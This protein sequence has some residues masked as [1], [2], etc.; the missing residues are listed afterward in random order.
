MTWNNLL[1]I[2]DLIGPKGD[3]GDTGAT[4]ATGSAGSDGKTILYG[5]VVPTSE[6]NDGDFYIRT[7]TNYLYGP[8][9]SGVWPSGTSLVGATGATGATG[10][11]GTAG[12]NGVDGKTILYGTSAPVSEGNN[13]DFYIRTS[14]N[15]LYGPKAAGVWPSGISLVGPTG[16]TGATG[17]PG[18]SYNQSIIFVSRA[19]DSQSGTWTPNIQTGTY[20]N[21]FS[22]S[23]STNNQSWTYQLDL[24]A[25]TWAFTVV[26]TASASAGI[27][28]ISIGGTSIGTVDTYAA[29]TTRNNRTTISGVTVAADGHYDVVFTN[30]NKNASSSAYTMNL[31]DFIGRRTGA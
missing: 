15:Y 8:K 27:I 9:A 1:A 29:S 20:H 3:T 6:G 4:G 19:P 13:G 18:A 16:A 31:Q 7:T 10:A 17:P 2:A 23:A 12:T 22:Q 26:Y 28:N 5:T 11:A 25:G 14:T 24:S 21:G 30:V